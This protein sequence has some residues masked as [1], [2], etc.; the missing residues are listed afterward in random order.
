VSGS[1]SRL[2]LAHPRD[3][4]ALFRDS[5]AIYRAHFWTFLALAAAIVVPVELIVQGIGMEQ[6]TAGYDST[7]TLAEMVVPTLVSFL[8][9]TPLITAVCIYALRH[10]AEG[11]RPGAGE[12]LV[13]G[14]EAFAPLFVAVALAALGIA[15]GLLL[16]VPGIY[17]FVRWYFVPQTVVLDGARDVTALR[18][19]SELTQGFWWRTLG[20]IVLVN[21]AAIVPGLLLI[22][23]FGAIAES[24]DRALWSLIGSMLTETLTAPF[25]AL[26]S[27][28][29]Y[30]DLRARRGALG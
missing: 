21:L 6:L 15:L 1:R 16:I 29:L 23:P 4:S 19:S 9:A 7:P 20:L 2:H 27:T 13:S 14:F 8:V 28:L 5:L 25:V 30:F 26:L 11:G 12:A 3:I 24:T 18:R 22:A 17:L 10:I